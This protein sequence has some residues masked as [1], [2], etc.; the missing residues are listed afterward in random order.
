MSYAKAIE[1][2]IAALEAEDKGKGTI[3]YRLRDAIFSR[4]RYWGEP[5]PIYYVNDVPKA[6]RQEDLP[7]VL[8]EVEHYLPTPEGAPPLGNATQWAWDTAQHKV[9]ENSKID[10]ITVFP[11]ELNTMPGWAGSSWY[12]NRYMDSGN[13][14]EFASAESLDYWREVDLYLG[15]SEHATGHL[16]YSRFWQKFLFDFGFVPVEEYA[17]KLINQGMILGTSAIIYRE[18]EPSITFPK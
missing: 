12:F 18:R 6:L 5:I 17:K 16:L 3:N 14:Q 11:L 4:Q 2:V 9:V 1:K 7:L 8:P 13:D 15:G 10:H